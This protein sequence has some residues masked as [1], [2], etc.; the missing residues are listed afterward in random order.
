MTRISRKLIGGL[1]AG[2]VALSA[3]TS[4][5]VTPAVAF[6]IDPP[7]NAMQVNPLCGVIQAPDGNWIPAPDCHTN[8]LYRS[9]DTDG[10]PSRLAVAGQAPSRRIY[11]F[12]D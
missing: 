4:A 7:Y 8:N 10:P 2:L 1:A 6:T 12:I 3:A 9:R 5:I 11:L